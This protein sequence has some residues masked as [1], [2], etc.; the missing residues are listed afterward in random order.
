MSTYEKSGP[1]GVGKRYG[2]LG[3]GGIQGI[4]TGENGNYYLDFEFS[5]SEVDPVNAQEFGIP[6]SYGLLKEVT[7]EVERA[8]DAGTLQIQYDGVDVLDAPIDLTTAGMQAGAVTGGSLEIEVG[9]V[10]TAVV[11]GVTGRNGYAKTLGLI[12]RI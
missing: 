5:A 1:G 12:A 9:K 2:A 3:L 11:T 8:F 7:V 4:T 6:A 10:F